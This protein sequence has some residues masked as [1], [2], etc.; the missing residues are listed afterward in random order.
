[1]TEFVRRLRTAAAEPLAIVDAETGAVVARRV[2]AA[3]TRT[4]RRR[5]LLSRDSLADAHALA[6]APCAAVH[7]VGMRFPIDVLFVSRGGRILKIVTDLPPWRI[8]GRLGAYA[9]V[10]LAA[11]ALRSCNV[12]VGDQLLLAPQV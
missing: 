12:R 1:M 9:A 7:T 4:A 3:L 6:I 11:G 8:A 5:G 2:E 10:E